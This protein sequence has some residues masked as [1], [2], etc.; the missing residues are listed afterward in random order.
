M[1]VIPNVRI[2]IHCAHTPK[3][4]VFRWSEANYDL[5]SDCRNIP[6]FSGGQQIE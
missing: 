4:G 2:T 3:I 5:C 1:Q 6:L